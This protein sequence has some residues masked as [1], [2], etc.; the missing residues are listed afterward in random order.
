MLN[1]ASRTL[2]NDKVASI[3]HSITTVISPRAQYV[4]PPQNP[5]DGLRLLSSMPPAML[6]R[7]AV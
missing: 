1:R 3:H 5:E 6:T 2:V 7:S 4:P